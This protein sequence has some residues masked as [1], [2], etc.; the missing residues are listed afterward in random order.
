ML[1]IFCCIILLHHIVKSYLWIV[2]VLVAHGLTIVTRVVMLAG[3]M[4]VVENLSVPKKKIKELKEQTH[5]N[6]NRL[7]STASRSKM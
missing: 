7:T 6:K 2:L 1:P 5:K 4:T 3:I